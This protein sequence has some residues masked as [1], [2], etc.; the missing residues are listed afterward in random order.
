MG[1][2]CIDQSAGTIGSPHDRMRHDN[3][4]LPVHIVNP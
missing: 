1:A 2:G 4:G 3:L